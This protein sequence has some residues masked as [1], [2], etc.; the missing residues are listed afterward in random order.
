MAKKKQKAGEVIKI[1]VI[2]VPVEHKP[3]LREDGYGK[4][5]PHDKETNG[6]KIEYSAEEPAE[7]KASTLFHEALHALSDL[8]CMELSEAQV[9]ALE[10]RLP[11]MIHDNWHHFQPLFDALEEG[12]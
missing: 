2:K 12:E 8:H 4:F 1:G 10:D 3:D 5:I 11:R 9:L 6:P 7:L